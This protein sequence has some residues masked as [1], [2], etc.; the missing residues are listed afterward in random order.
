MK[1]SQK[2]TARLPDRIEYFSVRL[3]EYKPERHFR[4]PDEALDFAE[5]HARENPQKLHVAY[6]DRETAIRA[7]RAKHHV[8]PIEE[9]IYEVRLRPE[10]FKV[11]R[12]GLD[13][14]A[15][16][17]YEIRWLKRVKTRQT[18]KNADG[19]EFKRE[20]SIDTEIEPWQPWLNV[21][22]YGGK[23]TPVYGHHYV[24]VTETVVEFVGREG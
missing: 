3:D 4:T 19:L 15:T 11:R 20:D 9:V 1:A 8:S 12:E 14:I 23:E 6:W 10:T 7:V 17:Q 24:N 22:D 2:L 5:A 18:I 21:R 13:V 16:G